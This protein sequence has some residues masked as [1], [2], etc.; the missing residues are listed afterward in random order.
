MKL[1]NFRVF[2]PNKIPLLR[3]SSPINVLWNTDLDIVKKQ[4]DE[5]L[6]HNKYAKFRDF[7]EKEINILIE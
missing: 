6:K 2:Y 3:N 5:Y 4:K 1:Y 7:V